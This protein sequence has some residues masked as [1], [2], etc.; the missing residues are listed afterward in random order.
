MNQRKSFYQNKLRPRGHRDNPPPDVERVM[1]IVG[2]QV[3]VRQCEGVDHAG[4]A[5]G[6]DADED[7]MSPEKVS[8]ERNRLRDAKAPGEGGGK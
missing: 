1:P 5:D 8:D 2:Q 4:Q 3:G 7:E 6:G